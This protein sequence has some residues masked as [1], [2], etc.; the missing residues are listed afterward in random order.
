MKISKSTVEKLVITDAQMPEGLGTLDPITVFAEDYGP[1]QGK[2]TITCFGEAWSHYW[3]HMGEKTKLAE[4]FRKCDEDYLAGKLKTGIQD[5]IEDD[6]EEGLTASLRDRI[7]KDRRIGD[8]DKNEARELW[9]DAGRVDWHDR[10]DICYRVFGDEWWHLTPQKPN[11]EY[12]YLCRII[13]T[14][15][16]ALSANA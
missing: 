3:S 15:Q 4:F 14:V 12:V 2:I 8:L 9:D 10:A 6:D 13:K 5:E 7:I 11:H 1:G 16:A